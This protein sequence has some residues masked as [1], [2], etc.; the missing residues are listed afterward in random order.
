LTIRSFSIDTL[1]HPP[2][3]EG[4]RK[5]G[6]VQS[7]GTI[8]RELSD[9]S[10]SYKPGS[11]QCTV[12]DT[13]RLLSTLEADAASKNWFNREMRICLAS[14][15]SI[16]ANQTPWTRFRGILT[17]N[18]QTGLQRTLTYLSALGSEFSPLDLDRT[19]PSRQVKDDFAATAPSESLDKFVPIC[20]GIFPDRTFGVTPPPTVP[21]AN[22]QWAL[23]AR[24]AAPTG[25][26][27]IYS[28]AGVV[29]YPDHPSWGFY[30]GVTIWYALA[31]VI[32]NGTSEGIESEP[33]LISVAIGSQG[34]VD[35]TWDAY[36][37][38]PILGWR[39]WAA[40]GS[41]FAQHSVL[42][43]TTGS[44]PAVTLPSGTLAYTDYSGGTRN[45]PDTDP[46][47]WRLALRINQYY[48]VYAQLTS[49]AD[50]SITFS[51]RAQ[52]G[53]TFIAPTFYCMNG[54]TGRL[55][56]ATVTWDP[57]T[58]PS[59]WTLTG[60]RIIRHRS[61]YSSW[62]PLFDVQFDVGPGVTSV[63][64]VGHGAA[65]WDSYSDNPSVTIPGLASAGANDGVIVGIPVGKATVN[66]IVVNQLM[67]CGH[68]IREVDDGYTSRDISGTGQPT[69]TVPVF[70]F[71]PDSDWGVKWWAPGKLGW[72]S[73][74][75]T[76]YV[77]VNSN[78]Y[79]I[80]YTTVD[81]LPTTVLFRACTMEDVSDGSGSTIDG[82]TRQLFH[83]CQNFIL[84]PSGQA[85]KSGAWLA[86]R[87][88]VDG[89]PVV[90]S[91]D[92]AANEAV[93]IA[94]I[95]RYYRGQIYLDQPTSVRDL[96][97]R[98]FESFGYRFGENHHGQF[99]WTLLD[100]F[101]DLDTVTLLTDVREIVAD[102]V[103][104]PRLSDM[105]N[106]EV[107]S[108]GYRPADST[109][110]VKNNQQV[111]D[112][113][114]IGTDTPPTGN[115]GRAKRHTRSMFYVDD[116]ETVTS[117]IGQDL[118]FYAY[119]PRYVTV[120]CS[121]Q[122]V[123]V[124]LGSI[125]QVND[126]QGIGATGWLNRPLWVLG[127]QDTY[128]DLQSAPT[129]QLSCVDVYPILVSPPKISAQIIEHVTMSDVLI[130]NTLTAGPSEHVR[131]SESTSRTLNPLGAFLT[132]TIKSSEVKL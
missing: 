121:L 24:A 3:Y 40:L 53:E 36:S 49:I 33:A 69:T 95:G 104:D 12:D 64:D 22:V 126:Y 14:N 80:V 129:I 98:A 32:D 86:P 2:T 34:Q 130:P 5:I 118:L 61:F 37:G 124:K 111:Q 27:A 26:T 102:T 77:V 123:P 79:T 92:V 101:T 96:L 58:A 4:G 13:D 1:N 122:A 78:W 99:F 70:D 55:Y 21:V 107:Y 73:M 19:L 132:E 82:A 45:D 105:A 90:N 120:V 127:I 51:P 52:S 75:A 76:N 85:W 93:E 56:N 25:F 50:G 44:R 7:M 94:R 112:D 128:N 74:S 89:T 68:A 88:F 46:P 20:M 41:S 15:E 9:R 109:G 48:L 117:V 11:G 63:D 106:T 131:V 83:L 71:I 81:P 97:G 8:N 28:N 31:A 67:L 39:M 30:D 72:S 43:E 29:Y 62:A 66:G 59:G 113:Y 54:P 60:Y 87:T 119:P 35:L 114:A 57:Y 16:I 47:N 115:R 108:Y 125:V 84:P 10:S 103:L 38:P 116:P 110:F 65:Y 23:D 18:Q 100:E 6:K 42:C 91:A 17:A